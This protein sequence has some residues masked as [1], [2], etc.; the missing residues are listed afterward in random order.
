ME[1]ARIDFTLKY[2][3][4]PKFNFR[5]RRLRTSSNR[6]L[7]SLLVADFILLMNCYI[8]VYQSF[9]GAPILG[10]YGKLIRFGSITVITNLKFSGITCS[11]KHFYNSIGCQVSGFFGSVAALSEIWSLAAVSFDRFKGIHSPLDNQKR[12]TNAQVILYYSKTKFIKLLILI[13]F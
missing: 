10:T 6:L 12:T 7:I 11:D 3:D 13:L 8:W 9:V 2:Q 1:N 5:A 4:Y